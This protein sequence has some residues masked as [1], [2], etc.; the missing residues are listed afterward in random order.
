MGKVRDDV[1]QRLWRGQDPFAGFPRRLYEVDLQGWGDNHVWLVELIDEVRPRV[2]LEMGVWKG[3][4]VVRMATRMQEL[5][6]DGVVIAVDTWLGSTEH[7]IND[8]EDLAIEGGRPALQ[9]KFMNNVVAR[10]LTDYVVPLPLDSLN[11]AHLLARVGIGLDL[12]HLDGGHDHAVV[13]ADLQAWWPLI[14]PGGVLLGDD[15]YPDGAWPGVKR[16]FDEFFGPSPPGFREF[17]GK[18]RITKPLT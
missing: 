16:A 7:W 11:A 12:M 18:C 15:Y 14:R 6:I 5:Q 17:S 2:A 4:S 8:R 3:A 13:S 10:G 9:R 1:V